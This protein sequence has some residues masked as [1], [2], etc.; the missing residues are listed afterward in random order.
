MPELNLVRSLDWMRDG[1]ALLNERLAD[2]SE[3]AIAGPSLLPGWSRAHVLTHLA[4][5]ANALVNL[6][7][8]ARTGVVTPM[9][10]DSTRRDTD[11]ERG[12]RRPAGEVL[13]DIRKADTGLLDAADA[14]PI[15]AWNAEVRSALGRTIRASEI[16]WMR[17][18][19]LWVHLID[20]NLGDDFGLLSED[21]IDALLADASA[22]VG[23]KEGCPSVLLK[24]DDRDDASY[25]LGPR[26]ESAQLVH[27]PA[28][29]LCGWLL[30]RDTPATRDIAART[31]VHLPAWL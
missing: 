6:T 28:A 20:L 31:D 7:V 26:V 18:R 17:T 16:P 12:A 4:R 29:G 2:L 19:E 22:G 27:G 21:L 9:Y 14:L 10:V 15:A 3:Q 24:P 1:S 11:I 5:N 30:G 8:W 25:R 23:A 13:A